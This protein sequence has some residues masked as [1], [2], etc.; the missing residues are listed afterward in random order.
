MHHHQPFPAKS[1]SS[2]IFWPD[3]AGFQQLSRM[4]IAPNSTGTNV[5]FQSIQ[6]PAHQLLASAV[7]ASQVENFRSQQLSTTSSL[8]TVLQLFCFDTTLHDVS[9]A[10]ESRTT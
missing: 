7:V 4:L 1:G 2:Q 10:D 9:A 3:L 6:A 8:H 5:D